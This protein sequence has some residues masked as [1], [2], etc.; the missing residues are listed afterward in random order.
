MVRAIKMAAD[1]IAKNSYLLK[2]LP[3]DFTFP[4]THGAI[5]R[6]GPIESIAI[7]TKFIRYIKRILIIGKGALMFAGYYSNQTDPTGIVL[8]S[9]TASSAKI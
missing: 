2:C 5:G 1:R 6:A 3:P 9:C 7:R 4:A 8:Y